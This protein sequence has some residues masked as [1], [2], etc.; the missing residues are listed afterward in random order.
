MASIISVAAAKN[1]RG[2]APYHGVGG[3][4]G[5]NEKASWRK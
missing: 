1:K 2:I 4:N 3:E 5:I